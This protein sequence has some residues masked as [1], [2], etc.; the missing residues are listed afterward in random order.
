MKPDYLDLS[1]KFH[2]LQLVSKRKKKKHIRRKQ[3]L[4]T[5]YHK[6]LYKLILAMTPK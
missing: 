6:L 5:K 4:K 1:F 3:T 2:P